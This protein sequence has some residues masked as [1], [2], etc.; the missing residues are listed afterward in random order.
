MITLCS[1]LFKEREM[2]KLSKRYNSKARSQP[3]KRADKRA[4]DD[5]AAG[6]LELGCAGAKDEYNSVAQPNEM[7]I[8]SNKEKKPKSKDVKQKKQL[9]KK[10]RKKLEKVI[11]KKKKKAKVI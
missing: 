7:V 11:E 9:S 4:E 1:D 2:G 8:K 10:Q 6:L 3:M 5:K